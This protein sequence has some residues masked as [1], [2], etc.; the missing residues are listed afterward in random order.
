LVNSFKAGTSLRCKASNS[1]AS[2]SAPSFA[3]SD[4][5][6]HVARPGDAQGL[7]KELEHLHVGGDAGLAVHLGADLDRL[8]RRARRRGARVQHAAAVAQ[9]R[10]AFA[11][12][13]VRVDAR[14]LRRDIGAH[15]H[16]PARQ[17]VDHLERAQLEVVPGAGEQ[18]VHVLEQRR[19]HQLVLLLE[20]EIEDLAAQAFD[21]HRFRRQDVFNVLREDPLH[22][23]TQSSRSR[24]TS[25]EDRPMKRICPSL[26]CVILRKVSR[27]RFGAMNG[28]T[29]SKTS[30][31]ASA[32]R[33]VVVPMALFSRAGG[34]A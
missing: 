13:E 5:D 20:E 23:L 1:S 34:A 7:A 10:H 6:A 29:P 14:H 11:V 30:I 22:E 31:R 18:R 33:N 4:V 2:R 32:I 16:H 28:S 21:A 17:L 25:I 9:A 3:V 8:A 24:P 12:E 19:H 27:H 15:A 26:S